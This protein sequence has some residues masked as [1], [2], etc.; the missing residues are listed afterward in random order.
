MIHWED[1]P[2][3][4]GP[5]YSWVWRKNIYWRQWREKAYMVQPRRNQARASSCPLSVVTRTA[6]PAC[7]VLPVTAAHLSLGLLDLVAGVGGH[8]AMQQSHNW[9][10][11][12]SPQLPFS[13]ERS[14]WSSITHGFSH[15]ITGV[16]PKLCLAQ[17]S[18]TIQCG[19]RPQ[20]DNT[21]TRQNI[22]RTQNWSSRR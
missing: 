15:T 22:P 18:Q 4:Q 1:W 12:L 13:E 6:P 3:S 17:T 19:P 8:V 10:Q 20:A 2:D 7:E 14:D 16:H 9:A 11:L 21:L 5:L